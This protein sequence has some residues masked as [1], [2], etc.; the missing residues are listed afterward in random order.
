MEM[1]KKVNMEMIREKPSLVD[2]EYMGE[3]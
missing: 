1:R 3:L 2:I